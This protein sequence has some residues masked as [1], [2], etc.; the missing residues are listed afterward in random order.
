[1]KT[2]FRKYILAAALTAS[3]GTMMAQ[4]LNSAYFTDD[5]KY[6]HDMNA[7]YGNEQTYIAI[8]VLGNLNVK[9]QGSFGVGD[10]L[11]KNPYYGNPKY[12]NAKKTATFMHPGISADEAL[13]GLDKNG[14]DLI[15]DMDIPIVSVGF[16]SWGGYNTI[17]IMERTHLGMQLPY[18]FFDFAKNMSNKEY[19]FDDLGMRGWS[20]AEIA[21]G[22]SR[23]IMDNLRVGAKVKI[24]LGAAYADFSMNGV[25]AKMVGDTWLIQGKARGELMMEGA[26]FKNVKEEY[27]THP[28][29]YFNRVDGVDY[30]NAGIGGFGLGLDLGAV[31]EFKDMDLDWLNGAK[32]SLAL[33][34]L[35]FISWSNTMVAE[36]SGD[37]FVFN[38]FKMRYENGSFESGGDQISDDLKDFANLQDKGTESGKTK[39]LAAT[40]RLGVEYP[41]PVYDKV[42]FGLLGTHRFDGIYSWTEGR[43]S[44]NYEPLKWLNGGIN[45][46]MTSFCTTM[47]WVLNVHPAG[48][49]FFVGMDHI[50]GKT[51]ASMIPLDSNVSF[52]L[53]MNIAFGSKKKKDSKDGL[54]T[55]S[56]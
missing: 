12:P 40:M 3:A 10:V 18:E 27:K 47:G 8:P 56:F 29:Q 48:F 34:D 17:E 32:V 28:G 53:G 7:A 20:Y 5:F 33:K 31:Y 35:G 4:E 13:K 24:L 14:N 30:D 15:F 38:G 39:A 9:L 49:N 16:K 52:N 11:F 44:A 23:K 26:K 2:S 55:L 51:G 36:S 43:L 46:G 50:I 54:S 6:R 21:F 37:P 41:L 19:S 1:M 42:K 25:S 45:L 22:H